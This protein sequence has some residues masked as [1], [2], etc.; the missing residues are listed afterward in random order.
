MTVQVIQMAYACEGED[1]DNDAPSLGNRNHALKTLNVLNQLNSE[2]RR[3][4]PSNVIPFI[5]ITETGKLNKHCCKNGGTCFLGTFCICPKHFS[6]RYCEYDT[7]IRLRHE[8]TLRLENQIKMLQKDSENGKV[9][10][11]VSPIENF[12]QTADQT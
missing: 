12:S 9:Q 4:N 10:D 11:K 7:R 6:G 1:C 2:K 3:N 8:W 5:G